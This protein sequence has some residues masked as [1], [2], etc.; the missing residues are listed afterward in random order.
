MFIDLFKD[1]FE[2]LIDFEVMIDEMY[3]SQW[4]DVGSD[5]NC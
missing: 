3:E 5:V 1:N 2:E 4:S